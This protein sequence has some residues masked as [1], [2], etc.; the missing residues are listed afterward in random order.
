MA[1]PATRRLQGGVSKKGATKMA[2][3]IQIST[4]TE[5]SK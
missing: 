4:I 3:T 5:N 2:K 1:K